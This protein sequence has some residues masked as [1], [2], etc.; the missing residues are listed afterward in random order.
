MNTTHTP[1]TLGSV[2]TGTLRAEDLLPAFANK[3]QE[4]GGEGMTLLNEAYHFL[5]NVLDF[6]DPYD[7]EYPGILAHDL[8]EEL[9]GRCPPFVFF[10]AHPGDGADFG[11]WPDWDALEEAFDYDRDGIPRNEVA[12]DDQQIIVRF[13]CD[14]ISLTENHVPNCGRDDVTVMDMD[15]NVLWTT[16]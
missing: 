7:V 8:V 4:L 2:S 14:C 16:T 5:E 11:F 15:R 1:F 6:Q 9:S 3:L 13:R 12:F 10:G